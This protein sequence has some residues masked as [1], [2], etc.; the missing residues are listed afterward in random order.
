MINSV[1]HS[2]SFFIWIYAGSDDPNIMKLWRKVGCAFKS[3]ILM[4]ITV[5]LWLK[6]TQSEDALAHLI[7]FMSWRIWIL[8]DKRVKQKVISACFAYLNLS[9][10]EVKLSKSWL[11]TFR[12][13]TES[14]H[15][16]CLVPWRIHLQNFLLRPNVDKPSEFEESV[17][18]R[19]DAKSESG[20]VKGFPS[21]NISP[22]RDP[23]TVFTSF[24][25]SRLV[26]CY[27][28]V[29]TLHST[30]LRR[31]QDHIFKNRPLDPPCGSKFILVSILLN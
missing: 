9:L 17:G 10:T 2:F 27:Y 20:I 18:V 12:H 16:N 5:T 4:L 6:V 1:V 22:S 31:I 15:D 26:S 25:V 7:S 30:T 13:N 14:T 19:T 23:Y 21:M 11:P 24:L 28:P 29:L 8:Q 3:N